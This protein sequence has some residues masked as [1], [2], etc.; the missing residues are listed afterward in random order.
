MSVCLKTG[1][2]IHV[3]DEG[4][5]LECDLHVVGDC[6]I[7]YTAGEPQYDPSDKERVT[8][9]IQK[10]SKYFYKPGDR[11]FYGVIV[12]QQIDCLIPID[13]IDHCIEYYRS[14]PLNFYNYSHG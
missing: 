7:A 10:G 1:G 4:S 11:N 13:M 8:L 3:E 6:V 12:A 9:T 14:V 5:Y 2:L